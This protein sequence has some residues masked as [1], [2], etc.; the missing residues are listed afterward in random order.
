M[1]PAMTIGI[2]SGPLAA[3]ILEY[4]EPLMF[5]AIG[6]TTLALAAA[7]AGELTIAQ[8]RTL[9]VIGRGDARVG[10]VAAAVGGSLSSTSRLIRRLERRGLVAT[11]RDESDRRAT[12]VRM[13]EAGLA[14]RSDVV[15]RR[16]AL[17]Q[18]ALERHSPRLPAELVPG[19]VV[20]GDAF[21]DYA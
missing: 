19:L 9:I 17:M 14:L 3:Q 15:T 11:E 20:I 7:S 10:E 18:R 2:E 21:A 5:G 4:L 12:R 13:T 1:L 6:M 16:R 8:W